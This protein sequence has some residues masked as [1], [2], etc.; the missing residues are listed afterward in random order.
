MTGVSPSLHLE[1]QPHVTGPRLAGDQRFAA[2]LMSA[3]LWGPSVFIA[4]LIG[5]LTLSL[6][7]S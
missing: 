7:F 4:S 1:T 3:P 2:K 5:L 6:F